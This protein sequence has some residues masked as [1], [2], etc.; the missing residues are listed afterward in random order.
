MLANCEVLSETF[1]ESEILWLTGC[2]AP[3]DTLLEGEKLLLSECERDTLEA[4]VETSAEGENFLSP[5][6]I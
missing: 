3:A 6:Q 1:A 4:L 2:E 5:S